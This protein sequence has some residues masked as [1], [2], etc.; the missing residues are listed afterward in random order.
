MDA[1][2]DEAFGRNDRWFE[3]VLFV[4][5]G[6]KRLSITFSVR[7]MLFSIR[8]PLLVSISALPSTPSNF[9][10]AS[11]SR[12]RVP[13]KNSSVRMSEGWLCINHATRV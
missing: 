4:V 3:Q 7:P 13:R 11:F 5:F 6:V 2:M 9:M 1:W 8:L 10:S 12:S